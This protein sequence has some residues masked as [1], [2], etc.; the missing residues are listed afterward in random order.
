MSRKQLGIIF[1]LISILLWATAASFTF[2]GGKAL[3]WQ[4]FAITAGISSICQ[5]IVYRLMGRSLRSI[6][7]PPAKLWLPIILG[8]V[9]YMLAYYQALSSASPRQAVGVNLINYLWPT[10]TI[11]LAVFFLPGG[12][13]TLRLAIAMLIALAGTVLA[14]WQPI[15]IALSAGPADVGGNLSPWPYI[16]AGVCAISWAGYSVTLARWRN[17]AKEYATAPIGVAIVAMVC[18]TVCLL[19]T[20]WQPMNTT[21]WLLVI[22]NGVGPSAGGYLFWELAL[23]RTDAHV[24]GLMGSAAPIL[25]TVCLWGMYYIVGSD[26]Q[27]GQ[28]YPRQIVAASMVA[29]AVMIALTQKSQAGESA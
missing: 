4:F 22:L 27:A 29:M 17:W 12:K 16:L 18:L 6:W 20:G 3:G 19:G 5:T 9:V 25:S 7:Q 24:L 8:L 14:N 10:L 11:L 23:H 1:G 26:N 13:M 15:G 21:Q 28:D 2:W